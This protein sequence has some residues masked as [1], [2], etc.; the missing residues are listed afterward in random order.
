M[1]KTQYRYIN[2]EHRNAVEQ[3][4]SDPRGPRLGVFAA[5]HTTLVDAAY[6]DLFGTRYSHLRGD[7]RPLEVWYKTS[8]GWVDIT[9]REQ[10]RWDIEHRTQEVRAAEQR[11]LIN[12]AKRIRASRDNTGDIWS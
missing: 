9:A 2:D 1:A 4:L 10:L 5:N 6:I 11:Q 8:D 7:D 3:A 12:E